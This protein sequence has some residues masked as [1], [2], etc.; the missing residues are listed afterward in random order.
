[1]TAHN[2]PLPP[3]P[4]CPYCGAAMSDGA[5][6]YSWVLGVATV[7]CIHCIAPNCRKALHFS[8]VP[9]AAGASANKIVGGFA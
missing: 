9:T 6:I 1:M 5:G 4:H 3:P 2:V 7:I 8:V